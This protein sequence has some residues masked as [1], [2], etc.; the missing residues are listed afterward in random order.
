MDTNVQVTNEQ[1]FVK[2]N[3]ANI[4]SALKK[5]LEVANKK[6]KESGLTPVKDVSELS[7]MEKFTAKANTHMSNYLKK[8][9]GFSTFKTFKINGQLVI[10]DSGF[11]T[12]HG[13]T[14]VYRND[15]G[16]VK[17]IKLPFNK[18]LKEEVEGISEENGELNEAQ[19]FVKKSNEKVQ[20]ALKKAVEETNKAAK[21]KGLT[22]IKD[23]SELSKMQQFKAS[24]ETVISGWIKSISN[25]HQVKTFKINGQLVLTDNGLVTMRAA[26]AVY[27][28]Q[29]GKVK[30][31]KLPFNKYL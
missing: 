15:K 11:L 2:K 20:P 30:T 29:D 31:V 3:N 27:R 7:K 17:V 8:I 19:T 4:Q 21:A 9:S 18:F 10:T 5:A 14:A 6:A 16:K 24:G 22:P 12:M 28:T 13:A 23:V 26:K 1:A 25:F